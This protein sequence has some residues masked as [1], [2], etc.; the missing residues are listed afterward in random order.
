MTD[1]P[2]LLDAHEAEIDRDIAEDDLAAEFAALAERKW[3]V[4]L[5][6]HALSRLYFADQVHGHNETRR[7]ADD[8][9]DALHAAGKLAPQPHRTALLRLSARL[10]ETLGYTGH[11]NGA[12][13]EAV[14][15]EA[16]KIKEAIRGTEP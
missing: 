3:A 13:L 6:D 10:N 7:Q 16:T 4:K 2:A 12:E 1:F 11:P 8:A 14:S 5:I 15:A 9:A